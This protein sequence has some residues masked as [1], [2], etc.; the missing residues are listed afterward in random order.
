MYLQITT[1]VEMTDHTGMHLLPQVL[2]P[3][4]HAYPQGLENISTSTLT[5]PRV[6]N[7]TTKTWNFWTRTI[8]T[9]FTGSATGSKLHNSLGPWTIDYDMHRFWN[10]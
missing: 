10:W 6:C 8:C 1:L 2:T 9:L 3:R 4:G 5:W 7:P